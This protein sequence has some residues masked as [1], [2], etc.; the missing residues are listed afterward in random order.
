[1]HNVF[2]ARGRWRISRVLQSLVGARFVDAIAAPSPDVVQNERRF[3][4]RAHLVYNW[5]D[6][7]FADVRVRRVAAAGE[8]SAQVA[9]IVGNC[10]EIK[11]HEFALRVIGDAGWRVAHVGNERQMPTTESAVLASLEAAGVVTHRGV[12]DPRAHLVSASAFLMP[13]LFEGMAVALAEAIVAG[14]PCLIA[15]APGL[16]WARG[17]DGVHLVDLRADEWQSVLRG[18][19]TD[20]TVVGKNAPDFSPARGVAEYLS[21]YGVTDQH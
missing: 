15:N 4:R 5:V 10:S 8:P 11:N 13:S 18:L 19:E 16:Q 17:I 6:P 9:L 12:G 1:V 14:V 2:L 20:A 21:L 7:S 3:F